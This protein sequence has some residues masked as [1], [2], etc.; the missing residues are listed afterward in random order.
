MPDCHLNA[1]PTAC[2][3]HG[4]PLVVAHDNPF[5][6]WVVGD[7]GGLFFESADQLAAIM[8]KPPTP[9]ERSRLVSSALATCKERFLWPQI[10]GQYES[11]V[12]RLARQ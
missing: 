7:Q 12:E 6:R 4:H 11:L 10:L 8:A 2:V 9:Q 3:R 1:S 5:N